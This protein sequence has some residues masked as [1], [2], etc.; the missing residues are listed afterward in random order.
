MDECRVKASVDGVRCEAQRSQVFLSTIAY[1][2]QESAPMTKARKTQRIDVDDVCIQPKWINISSIFSSSILPALSTTNDEM[3]GKDSDNVQAFWLF[4]SSITGGRRC[5]LRQV[6]LTMLAVTLLISVFSFTAYVS[7]RAWSNTF[8]A[9]LVDIVH[10]TNL[11]TFLGVRMRRKTDW[12]GW[13][14]SWS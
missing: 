5:S 8:G 4:F 6:R 13:A 7:T 2:E 11:L 12:P 9:F 3:F 1:R 10:Y 14:N